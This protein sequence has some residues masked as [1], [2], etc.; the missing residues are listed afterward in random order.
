MTQQYKEFDFIGLV[1][2]HRKKLLIFSLASMTIMTPIMLLLPNYYEASTLIY[3]VGESLQQPIVNLNDTQMSLFGND[4][5]VDRLLSIANAQLIKQELIQSLGLY[6]HYYLD[7][8]NRK[9]R[10]KLMKKLDK[11]YKVKKTEWD[12]V[13]VSYEDTSA[14]K[15]AE[16]ANKAVNIIDRK[17][18]A[19]AQEAKDVLIEAGNNELAQKEKD[20]ILLTD[21]IKN[22]KEEHHIYDTE[23]QAEALAQ[24]EGNTPNNA[25]VQDRIQRFLAGVSQ[26]KNLETQ[27]TELSRWV[28]SQKNSLDQL[29]YNQSNK[30]SA[31][32]IIDRAQIPDQKSRPRRSLYVLTAG[33]GSVF[34]SVM[35]LMLMQI[36]GRQYLEK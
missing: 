6:Q 4:R 11:Y 31:I 27:Q 1:F 35:A 5:D 28:V 13:E 10:I 17:A 29:K 34:I 36:S 24:M 25:V 7:S 18:V 20:L 8:T 26:I 9:D 33:I 2:T 15:A 21:Q 14:E 32:H 30:K 12:A 23:K 22:L 16:F 19:L 3:P